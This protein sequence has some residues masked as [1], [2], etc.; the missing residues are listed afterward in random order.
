MTENEL[1]SV[2][3]AAKRL[4]VSRSRVHAL[5]R[6]GRLPATLISNLW[7]IDAK[8]LKLV[9]DRPQGWPKGR[10]RGRPKKPSDPEESDPIKTHKSLPV[11]H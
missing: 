11:C 6:T 2:T 10:K 1:I 8:D 7:V 9:E 4:G 5:I 3:E